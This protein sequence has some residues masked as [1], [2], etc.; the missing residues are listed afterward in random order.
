MVRPALRAALALAQLV[1]GLLARARLVIGRQ[2]ARNDGCRAPAPCTPQGFKTLALAL[3]SWQLLALQASMCYARA[4]TRPT[5][6]LNR[7]KAVPCPLNSHKHATTVT[8]R[9]HKGCSAPHTSHVTSQGC[10]A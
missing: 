6:D 5:D 3:L 1:L 8:A 10:T 9:M 7:L 2:L 4:V